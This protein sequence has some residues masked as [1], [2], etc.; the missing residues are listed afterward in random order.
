MSNGNRKPKVYENLEYTNTSCETIQIITRLQ[1]TDQA[2]LSILTEGDLLELKILTDP[3]AIGAINYRGEICGLI[4][5]IEIDQLYKCMQDN[6][7]FVAEVLNVKGPLCDVK[8][9][10]KK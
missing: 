10:T 5:I 4:A 9:R 3:T 8:V 1:K 7:K 2:A 6:Y